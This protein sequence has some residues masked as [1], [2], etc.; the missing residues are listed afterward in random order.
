MFRKE[1]EKWKG[2]TVRALS[3]SPATSIS[4]STTCKQTVELLS[5]KYAFVYAIWC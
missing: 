3:L 2:A 5:Q 1:I 4:G